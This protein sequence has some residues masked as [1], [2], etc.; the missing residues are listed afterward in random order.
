MYWG[1][2]NSVTKLHLVGYCY[3][4]LFPCFI[5]FPVISFCLFSYLFCYP[6][7]FSTVFDFMFFFS[8]CSSLSLS[9]SLSLFC[10]YVFHSSS[11]CFLAHLSI[12]FMSVP[13]FFSSLGVTVISSPKQRKVIKSDIPTMWTESLWCLQCFTQS[14][15]NELKRTLPVPVICRE[16]FLS[17]CPLYF[18]PTPQWS[19]RRVNEIKL[20]VIFFVRRWRYLE[21]VTD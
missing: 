16:Q 14:K 11:F 13:S 4:V 3:E 10:L 7:L 2:I 1:I 18:I 8:F 21:N 17:S 6:I 19:G 20:S 15:H 9:L 5:Y 12:F